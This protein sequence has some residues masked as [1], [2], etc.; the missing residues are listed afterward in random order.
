M[1]RPPD[2][3]SLD[4]DSESEEE[5]LSAAQFRNERLGYRTPTL[6]ELRSIT[7]GTFWR[8]IVEK[9]LVQCCYNKL[10]SKLD[11]VCLRAAL[12]LDKAILSDQ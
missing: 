2:F 5:L 8:G 7:V 9:V 11:I 6:R 3:F 10:H 12:I 1:P 4:P